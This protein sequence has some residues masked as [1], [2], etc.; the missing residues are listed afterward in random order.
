MLK[1][2]AERAVAARAVRARGGRRTARRNGFNDRVVD[3]WDPEMNAAG[4][5]GLSSPY[6][7]QN[8][9][10]DYFARADADAESDDADAGVTS[11]SDGDGVG[12]WLDG[13]IECMQEAGET[14][15]VPAGWWHIVLNT[16]DT[17]AITENLMSTHNAGQVYGELRR[18][19]QPR[20]PRM[21]MDA[22][23]KTCVSNL[24]REFPNA[25]ARAVGE[26]RSDGG[27]SCGQRAGGPTLSAC[28]VKAEEEEGEGLA[29][30]SAGGK[31]EV[32]ASGE[33]EAATDAGDDFDFI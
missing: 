10:L 6:G 28:V 3:Y 2:E 25:V 9:P 20:N 19:V 12:G 11:G 14:I 15:Y 32:D 7:C 31:V 8:N 33:Q 27:G 5:W 16:E 26:Q 29:A 21:P 4:W 22:R 1:K 24:R 23:P 30:I 17:V 18:R 13:A